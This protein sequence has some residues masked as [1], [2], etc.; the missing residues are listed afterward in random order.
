M[1]LAR[2]CISALLRSERGSS[3]KVL[4]RVVNVIVGELTVQ[5]QDLP[6]VSKML[7]REI[8]YLLAYIRALVGSKIS[9]KIAIQNRTKFLRSL[10]LASSSNRT[11]KSMVDQK[12]RARK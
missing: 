4:K 8:C 6:S 9:R 11:F 3:G 5:I 1:S 7:L 2:S 12:R 10:A